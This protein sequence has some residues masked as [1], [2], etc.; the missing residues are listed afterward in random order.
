MAVDLGKAKRILSQAFLE[1]HDHINEDDAAAL[2]VKSEM[3]IRAL[4]EEMNADEKLHAATQIVKDLSSGY[5]N[6]IRY[7]EAKVQYLLAKI[8]EIQ[9]GNVNPD[10]SV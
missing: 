3:Q 2:V 5:R 7:E 8:E 6:A 9:D 1:N 10:A 4:R